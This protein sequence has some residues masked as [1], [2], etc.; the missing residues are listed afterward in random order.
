MLQY[1]TVSQK[2]CKARTIFLFFRIPTD[3]ADI[4]A[5][6]KCGNLSAK[7]NNFWV[8]CRA[9]RDFV[10]AQGS[11][12]CLPLRGTIPDMFSDSERYIQLQNVYREQ[13]DDDVEKVMKG[14]R[15]HLEAV[16][17]PP[18]RA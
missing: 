16:G 11:G 15:T 10:E 7:S 1:Y 12:A 17:R 5:D 8:I 13:A 2:H 14:V 4:L 6:E 18:V 3:V 9:V